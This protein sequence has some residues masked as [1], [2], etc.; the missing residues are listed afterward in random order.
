[1]P[2]ATVNGS[3]FASYGGVSTTGGS[4]TTNTVAGTG[5]VIN[6]SNN[7]VTTLPTSGGSNTTNYV[8]TDPGTF[9]LTGNLAVGSLAVIN[10][11]SATGPTIIN[12]NGWTLTVGGTTGS[13]V[14]PLLVQGTQNL[15]INSAGGTGTGQN[16]ANGAIVLSTTLPD[17]GLL[18]TGGGV[19]A[20]IN[21][22]ITGS[23]GLTASGPGTLNLAATNNSLAVNFTGNTTLNGEG[24][25]DT[26]TFGG[27]PAGNFTLSYN[28]ATTGPIAYSSTPSTLQSNILSALGGLSTLASTSNV[29][30]AVNTGATVATVTVPANLLAAPAGTL[31]TSGTVSVAYASAAGTLNLGTASTPGSANAVSS[32]TLNLISGILQANTTVVLT[33]AVTLTNSNLTIAGSNN[34]TITST[35][36]APFTTQR[37]QRHAQ[38]HQYGG[39]GAEL[40]GGGKRAHRR[41]HFDQAGNRCVDVYEQRRRQQQ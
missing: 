39:H 21:S 36:A 6:P 41:C 3:N 28:G 26:I 10:D 20:T 25:T 2:Y 12:L 23:A 16:N 33:N 24:V 9:S 11:G 27:T 30:V 5:V 31:S 34:I 7:Y 38:R 15:T 40:V 37:R 4:P 32:G 8:I 19:T 35:A 14:A 13:A 18:F 29:S 1:M 22:P 17:E